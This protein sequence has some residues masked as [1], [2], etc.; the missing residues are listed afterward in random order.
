MSDEV[1]PAEMPLEKQVEILKSALQTYANPN[2]W[3]KFVYFADGSSAYV[4]DAAD[5]GWRA[6]Y[7]LDW[8]EGKDTYPKLSINGVKT[9]CQEQKEAQERKPQEHRLG[10]RIYS[11]GRPIPWWSPVGGNGEEE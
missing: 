8:I 7:A 2:S 4:P 1:K 3:F 9:A 11:Y 6:R 10:K 5:S